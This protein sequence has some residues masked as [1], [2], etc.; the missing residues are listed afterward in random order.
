MALLLP[1]HVESNSFSDLPYFAPPPAVCH[2]LGWLAA[3]L[4]PGWQESLLAIPWLSGFIPN[5]CG[6]W[7]LQMSWHD[8]DCPSSTESRRWKIVPGR[9]LE[10]EPDL[11]PHGYCWIF[12]N[13]FPLESHQHLGLRGSHP[14]GTPRFSDCYSP[15]SQAVL[16]ALNS[17]QIF[18]TRPKKKKGNPPSHS[19]PFARKSSAC[20]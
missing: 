10:G 9:K 7:W 13:L 16:G 15:E 20:A 5:Y 18:S 6:L 12:P 1:A 11:V 4:P 19:A 17:M 14:C 2:L 8:I 3:A